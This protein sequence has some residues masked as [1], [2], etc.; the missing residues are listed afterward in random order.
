MNKIKSLL[1][2][3]WFWLRSKTTLDEKAI[4]VY[5][6]VKDRAKEMKEEFKDVKKAAKNLTSQLK[7]VGGAAKGKKEEEDLKKIK[8]I[9]K[10]NEKY[11]IN[12]NDTYIKFMYGITKNI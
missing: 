7:D 4:E 3:F 8:T 1:K 10:Q 12:I 9:K 5:E 11:N 2:N 6:E